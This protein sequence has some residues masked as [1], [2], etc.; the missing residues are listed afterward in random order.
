MSN[1]QFSVFFGSSTE[2]RQ[3]MEMVASWIEPFPNTKVVLWNTPQA[4]PAGCYTFDRL[5]Q[6]A[7]ICH[8]AVF[9]FGEDDKV[10]YRNA[11]WPQP[12]GNVLL[13]YGLFASRLGIKNTL[14]CRV[15]KSQIASDLL[16]ITTINF[17]EGQILSGK[18]AVE[19]WFTLAQQEAGVSQLAGASRPRCEH[20]ARHL[21]TDEVQDKLKVLPDWSVVERPDGNSLSIQHLIQRAFTFDA[22]QDAI[23][24]MSIAASEVDR[25]NH[26]PE[27]ENVWTTV[28]VRITTWGVGSNITD[29]D[30]QLARAL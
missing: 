2:S 14:I 24:F 26:H 4:F 30:I 13:E 17:K 15:A 27:W 7:R 3:F 19:H 23:R 28:T 1:T 16:G 12:R 21:L 5:L 29:L 25:L 20:V 8:A 9:I 18:Q 11:E 6:L 10:W 22:F